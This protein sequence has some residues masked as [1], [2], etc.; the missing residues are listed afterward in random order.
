MNPNFLAEI[1]PYIEK[2]EHHP[3]YEK[4][5][6]KH[7]LKYFMEC[8]VYAVFDFMSLVKSLQLHFAP[9]TV[10]W[11]PPRHR[12][13]ARFINEI[14][15][16]EES[17]IT[18]QN[19]YMSHYELYLQ[20]MQEIEANT[21]TVTNWVSKI[22]EDG[23]EKSWKFTN[24]IPSS[25]IE[26][27]EYTFSIIASDQIHKIA[28]CFCFGR[29]KAIPSMFSSLLKKMQVSEK[30]AP[31]F[32]YYLQRHIEVDGDSHGP[33]ALK[34]LSAL[35]GDNVQMWQ[36]AKEVA[37]ASLLKRGKFWD[38]VAVELGL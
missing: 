37:I 2:L 31:H 23:L 9:V 8:H 10:P 36:E 13:L 35:C 32:H 30:E 11:T 38:Q 5:T 24:N 19:N 21:D 20:S 29:E 27:M 15:L 18:Q 14:V 28:A 17:D 7:Q 6:S 22:A 16:C 4:I 1:S 3:L 34:M 26:F 33:L 12:E 25:A